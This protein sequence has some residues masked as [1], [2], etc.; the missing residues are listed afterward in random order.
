MLAKLIFENL[1]CVGL[2]VLYCRSVLGLSFY[3][4]YTQLLWEA[5]KNKIQHKRMCKIEESKKDLS[6]TV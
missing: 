1:L 4:K 3:D 2:H 6:F 5:F